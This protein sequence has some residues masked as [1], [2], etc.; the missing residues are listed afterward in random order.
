[1]LADPQS[2]AFKLNAC[3][4]VVRLSKLIEAFQNEA[5]DRYDKI[6]QVHSEFQH[7]CQAIVDRFNRESAKI[8]RDL[9][10]FRK[11][12]I[13]STCSSFSEEYKNIKRDFTKY[14]NGQI[15][16][17]NAIIVQSKN[18][19][20]AVQ[21]IQ[22]S[23]L[24]TAND[25]LTSA[26]EMEENLHTQ[27]SSEYIETY[28]KPHTQPIFD[29]MERYVNYS[30]DRLRR[31]KKRYDTRSET[32]R[33]SFKTELKNYY[34]SIAPKTEHFKQKIK[35]L[36]NSIFES[37]MQFARL[38]D[39]NKTKTRSSLISKDSLLRDTTYACK[40]YDDQMFLLRER[41]KTL[42]NQQNSL[43]LDLRNQ[44]QTRRRNIMLKIDLTTK[45]IL[46]KQKQYSSFVERWSEEKEKRVQEILANNHIT[47]KQNKT[48]AAQKSDEIQ[49]QL[50]HMKECEDDSKELIEK[51]KYLINNSLIRAKN[52]YNIFKS[53]N[54]KQ[55][56]TRIRHH[57]I[58]VRD[59]YIISR[60]SRLASLEKSN[61]LQLGSIQTSIDVTRSSNNQVSRF[62]Q[63]QQSVYNKTLDSITNECKN[64]F[65]NEKR[66]LADKMNSRK[67]ELN[68][69][70]SDVL[71]NYQIDLSRVANT[72][73]TDLQNKQ[74]HLNNMIKIKTSQF[75]T[76]LNLKD[77][78]DP[79]D[80]SIPD[81]LRSQLTK[82]ETDIK[83]LQEQHKRT[84]DGYDKQSSSLA[85]LIRKFQR[86]VVNETSSIS[87]EYEMKIQVEQVSLKEKLE[88]LSKIYDPDENQRGCDIIEAFRK[89]R[90]VKSSMVD[91]IYAIK[92]LREKK[93][94]EVNAKI[95]ELKE[96]INWYKTI[97]S[98]LSDQLKV[99]NDRAQREIPQLQHVREQEILPLQTLINE[100]HQKYQK[101][102]QKVSK[103]RA[104]AIENLEKQASEIANEKEKMEAQKMQKLKEIDA[105]YDQQ[106]QKICSEHTKTVTALRNKVAAAR[107]QLETERTSHKEKMRDEF[108]QYCQLLKQ[109][110][111]ASQAKMRVVI[112][113]ENRKLDAVIADKLNKLLQL[114]FLFSN[115]P[116]R[117][118][119]KK[120][121]EVQ[122]S[123][124]SEVD[125]ATTA[126][127]NY[128]ASLIKQPSKIVKSQPQQSYPVHPPQQPSKG[129]TMKPANQKSVKIIFESTYPSVEQKARPIV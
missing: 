79:T 27:V 97:E 88:N 122:K 51:L 38:V 114:D 94:K 73:S 127:F 113:K 111:A 47:T 69:E 14:K 8:S 28:I 101:E 90:E 5:Q 56:E 53:T 92:K 22:N 42:Q 74:Q 58:G 41:L 63:S 89:V 10:Q 32:I 64:N 85:K 3:K 119:D 126:A 59:I 103:E 117:R 116:P 107:K 33:E 61:G 86:N 72:F 75:R 82:I 16:K 80:H 25:T 44:Y 2:E 15:R 128:H 17:L 39:Q 29:K 121:I 24:K 76:S 57:F 99:A 102:N 105:K 1:M 62:L 115:L 93:K 125:K 21:L 112:D 109:N 19:Q 35:E 37:K 65:E 48:L 12:Y 96:K 123:S 104:K 54:L 49:L 31:M 106:K 55:Q 68:N 81:K 66:S 6:N 95:N 70:Y 71:N 20:Q 52:N 40:D 4:K 7:A 78:V 118:G 84:I 43:I 18:L 46:E 60:R 83:A 26:N 110:I 67:T 13:S 120:K 87:S 23:T 45:M 36:K 30:D 50:I 129:Q 124:L 100:L 77:P 34:K 91:E 11:D 98:C 9:N 108:N